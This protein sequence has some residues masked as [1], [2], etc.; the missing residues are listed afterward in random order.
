MHTALERRRE[1]RAS[2]LTRR[3]FQGD[4]L[5]SK[6]LPLHRLPRDRMQNRRYRTLLGGLA[7]LALV[8]GLSCSR[9]DTSP[10]ALAAIDEELFISTFVDLR[11]AALS[12][13]GGELDPAERERILADR[14]VSEEDL[15]QFVEVHGRDVDFMAGVWSRADSLIAE[16]REPG[17]ASPT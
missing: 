8:G 11:V 10:E 16:M 2:S 13:E 17:R 7:V 6:S 12:A 9:D 4:L 3:D 14:G 1:R 15:L 5:R